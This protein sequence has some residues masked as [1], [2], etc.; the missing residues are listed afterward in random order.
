V[1]H[2][3]YARPGV[4]EFG[5]RGQR[6]PDPAV[7]GD[8]CTGQWNIEIAADEHALTAQITQVSDGFHDDPHFI[9]R[10]LPSGWAEMTR[11]HASTG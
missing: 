9:R 7:I 5:Q 4:Q 3:S 1:G 10:W 6:R 8:G 2:D 11:G